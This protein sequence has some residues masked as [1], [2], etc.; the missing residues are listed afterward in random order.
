MSW[1]LNRKNKKP[2][3]LRFTL[4]TS[5]HWIRSLALL[6]E[7]KQLTYYELYTNF[8]Q[9][10]RKER[11]EE[12][13]TNL[14][15]SYVMAL[16]YLTAL[17][18]IANASGLD[19]TTL[20]RI[21]IVNWYYG[22]YNASQAMI[23]SSEGSCPES[24]SK[25]A[26]SWYE[27]ILKPK[28]SSIPS[29]FHYYVSSLVEG[30]DE[31]EINETITSNIHDTT[32]P[33]NADGARAMCA[34]YLQGTAAWYRE[35]EKAKVKKAQKFQNF[36]TNRNQKIRDKHLNKQQ[37][38]FLHEAYRF[39]GKGNYRDAAFIPYFANAIESE[40]FLKDL[41]IIL[42]YFI[43]QA[44]AYSHSVVQHFPAASFCADIQQNT[45]LRLPEQLKEIT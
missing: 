38:T 15:G 43:S 36:R 41:E 17:H 10:K 18:T 4:I 44:F 6:I 31:K 28:K 8:G 35:Q 23:W 27:Y 12:Q 16:D 40:E 37:V 1:F 14:F 3:G 26:D 33:Q 30:E 7:Q 5:T 29:P 34:S 32:K 2:R 20:L 13:L 25:T 19:K 11:S 9:I 22:I 39:R 24:H 21:A 45:V 42:A